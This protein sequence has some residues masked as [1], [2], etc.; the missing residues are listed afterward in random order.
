MF[1]HKIRLQ[2]KRLL[3]NG[4]QSGQRAAEIIVKHEIVIVAR[5]PCRRDRQ[6][7]KLNEFTCAAR[8]TFYLMLMSIG[9][10]TSVRINPGHKFHPLVCT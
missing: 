2:L 9:G 4:R 1:L 5:E 6:L 3:N 8:M 10:L 7:S